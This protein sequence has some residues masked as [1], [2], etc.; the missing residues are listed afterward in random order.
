MNLGDGFT[1]DDPPVTPRWGST[2]AA[3]RAD[4]GDRV[5]EVTPLYLVVSDAASLGGLTCHVGLHFDD[6]QRLQELE[7]FRSSYAE[8]QASFDGFQRH[9]EA[10]FGRPGMSRPGTAGFPDHR[11]VVR[12]VEIVHYV[13]DRYGPEEHMRVRLRKRL[14]AVW[15]WR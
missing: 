4:L 1:L 2:P 7:F 10:A 6:R 11:W 8:P 12:R 3:I 9:F 13:I 14:L 15:P 5:R